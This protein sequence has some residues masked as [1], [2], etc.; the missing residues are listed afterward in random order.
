M[1]SFLRILASFDR[2]NIFLGMVEVKGTGYKKFDTYRN[3][4]QILMNPCSALEK[5]SYS[6]Q[7]IDKKHYAHVI[8]GI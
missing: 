6:H 8:Q 1:K 5:T 3:S 2:I 4:W 7:T